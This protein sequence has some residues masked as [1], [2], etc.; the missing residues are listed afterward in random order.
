MFTLQTLFFRRRLTA[1][2]LLSLGLHGVGTAQTATPSP[3][4]WAARLVASLSQLDADHAARIGVHVRDLDSGETAS[5][6]STQRWYL[7]SMV[8]VPVAIAVLRGVERGDL[9]LD[10]PVTLRASDYVDGAGSTNSRPVGASVRIRALLEQ[11][12]IHSDNTASDMLIDL[13]GIAEVNAVVE[14]LVP[15]RFRRITSLADVRR[16]IYGQLTPRAERLEG[17]DLLALRRQASDAERLRLLSQLTGTSVAQFRLPSLDAAYAAY[18]A[19]GLNTAPLDA[20]ADLLEAL[21]E[22]KALRPT[23]TGYLLA[24]MER[25]VTGKRR[26]QLGLPKDARFAQKTGTQRGRICD[27]GLIRTA[28]TASTPSRRVLVVACTRDEPSLERS[29]MALAQVGAAICRSGLLTQGVPDAPS[30]PALP[31]ADR[32]PAVPAER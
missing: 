21:V 22:G 16:E 18:Y 8:K 7:A 15:G 4:P 6:Q 30:C 13:V 27:G 5:Y 25:V 26:I 11:M 20:Y 19:Q 10:T 3:S 31:R 17:R 9:T 2:A 32:L 28:A 14:S 12:I 23:Y 29:E 1:A 24:M